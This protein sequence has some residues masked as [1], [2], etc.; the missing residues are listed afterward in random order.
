MRFFILSLLFLVP[1][2]SF[3]QVDDS[4]SA[5]AEDL[6]ELDL[7]AYEASREDSILGALRF[8]HGTIVIADGVATLDLPDTFKFLGAEQ[9]RLVLLEFWDN[10]PS[11]AVGVAGIIFPVE[12][13][14]YDDDFAFIVSFEETG[15]VSDADADAIDYTAKLTRMKV[16]DQTENRER[17]AQG[18]DGLE[19]VGW[20]SP[21]F[22]DKARKVL[23]WA[24]EMHSDNAETNVLNYNVRV[25]GRRGVL[26]LNAIGGMHLLPKVEASIPAVLDM[27][28]F[29][30]GHRYDQ[31]DP[32]VDTVSDTGLG[33]LIDGDVKSR[34]GT[35]LKKVLIVAAVSIVGL[36][37]II[38]AVLLIMRR[39]RNSPMS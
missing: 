26:V 25:L 38:S 19:L 15:Y 33:G 32:D 2:L 8:D 4:I 27:T 16:E 6:D 20:A 14:V 5:S 11:S 18:F 17:R 24:K 13:G 29:N 30:D 39:R 36:V 22:Y 23:H 34:M 10:P 37:A 28:S 9:S 1:S 35:V 3:A 7:D 31:F 21:P 12:A